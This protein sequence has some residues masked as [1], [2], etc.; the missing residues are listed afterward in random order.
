MRRPAATLVEVLVVLVLFT[1]LIATAYR[2]IGLVSGR[3]G[4]LPAARRRADLA[5][6]KALV[7]ESLL[8]DVRSSVGIAGSPEAGYTIE[9]FVVADDGSFDVVEVTWRRTDE[10]T[11]TR[12]AGD[13][14]PREFRFHGLL[15]DAQLVLDLKIQPVDD[16]LFQP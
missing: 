10:A 1:G 4:G 12:R 3:R 11:I 14:P 13:G 8:R 7:F 2:V 15:D 5:S 9:R 16:V 6:Q